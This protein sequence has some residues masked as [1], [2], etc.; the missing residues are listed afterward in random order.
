M[1]GK[2]SILIIMISFSLI[3]I[4]V[5]NASYDDNRQV[6]TSNNT[7]YEVQWEFNY[8]PGW[9]GGRFQGPQP[10]GDSDNDGENELL[11][12]GRDATLTV[13]EWNE[14][15]QEYIEAHKLHSPFYFYFLIRQMLTGDTPPDAGG[16]AI[17]DLTGD[18]ENEIA[19]TWYGAVYKFKNN[20]Y[21]IIGLNSWIFRNGGG[22]GDC[23][24]GDCDNDGQNELIMSGGGGSREN[25]VPEIV[26][27]KW[28]GFSMQKVASYDYPDMG[29]A[30]MCGLEDLDEDGENEIAVGITSWDFS[31]LHK[32]KI[33]VLD[34]NEQTN[35]FED[36]VIYEIG[37]EFQMPFGGWCSDSDM[38][39]KP[40]IHI[41]YMTPEISIFEWDGDEYV[42]KFEKEWP[43]EG[44]L[45]EG[46][47]VGD[48]DDDGIPEVC[49][50]TDDVHILQWNGETYIEEAVITESYGDL[51]VVNVG[52]CDNDGKNEISVAPVFVDDGEDYIQW[53]FKYKSE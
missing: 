48:V 9:S 7:N 45:I 13:V 23:F 43:G 11:I 15:S 17:G 47:N 31:P 10:I 16:F 20:R 28:N 22:N 34:W 12:A 53:I 24:I 37:Q 51:A 40:E 38:D 21:Q 42:L 2:K 25:P 5:V 4:S 50:G 14:N 33:I 6:S 44:M 26:I 1:N 35:D 36:T 3:S 29:Y 18:G 52:D 30:Y 27:L 46:L 39:G 8:G 19:A 49:A 41:G 32:H